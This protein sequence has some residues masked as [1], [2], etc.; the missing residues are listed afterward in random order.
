MKALP[1]PMMNA[2]IRTQLPI[3][4]QCFVGGYYVAMNKSINTSFLSQ[5]LMNN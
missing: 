5:Q 2:M 1:V 3:I 4:L